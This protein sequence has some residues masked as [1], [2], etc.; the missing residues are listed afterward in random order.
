MKQKIHVLFFVF[1]NITSGS[2]FQKCQGQCISYDVH[3]CIDYMDDLHVQGNQMWWVNFGGSNPG[4]HSNCSGDVLSVNGNPWGLWS[5]PYTLAGVTNCMDMTSSVTLCSDICNLIQAPSAS[6]NWETIY[7]F[8]DSGPSGP[9]N[10]KIVF[11]YCPTTTIPSST[12]SVSATVCAGNNASF[13]YTGG[14]GSSAT[15]S[16]NFVDGSPLDTAKN[17]THTYANSGTYSV[18]LNVN[19]CNPSA[20]TIIPVTVSTTPTSACTTGTSICIGTN[21][22]ITYTGTGVAS[23]TYTWNF[24]GGNIVSGSG[25]GPYIVN[26]ATAGTQLVTLSVNENGCIS[27][28]ST[29]T[30]I[31][32]PAPVAN[33]KGNNVCFNNV[34][35]FTDLSVGNNTV[36]N[37]S[38]NF[39]DGNT[40]TLQSPTH[41]YSNPGSYSVT[42]TITNNF[43]CID[44]NSINV[45]V[46]PLPTV[47]FSSTTICLGNSTCFG[48][49]STITSGSIIGWGWNFG[50]PNSGNNNTST[51]QNPCHTYTNVGTFPVILTA[52]SDSGCQILKSLP[53]TINQLPVA[54]F[55]A[56][57]VC[58]NTSATFANGT[59][60]ASGD[61]IATWNWNFGNAPAGTSAAQNPAYSYGT[62]GT[63]SVTLIA[64]S[65]KGCIDTIIKS[66]T[67]YK[68]PVAAFSHP[69]SG[70]APLNNVGFVNASTSADGTITNWLWNFSGGNP[71]S[72]IQ[73][74]PS[75]ISFNNPGTYNVSLIVMTN[76]GCRD[77]LQS[78][79]YIKVFNL[80]QAGFCI[81]PISA[82]T[83]VNQPIFNFCN[84]WSAD[85]VQWTWNFGDGTPT[86]N[87]STNPIHS[88]STTAI[89]NS[90]YIYNVC[91][92]VLNQHGCR[93]SICK[94]V[95]LLPEFE[96]YAPNSFTP[97]G[98]GIN[99][100]FFGKGRG[101]TDYSIWI[102]DRWGNSVWD[103]HYSGKNIDWDNDNFNGHKQDG[104][105]SA[106]KWDGKAISGG[107]SMNGSSGNIS[108]EEVYVWK[109]EIIDIFDKH[110]TYTGNV[111][112][113]K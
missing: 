27:P 24:S 58:L 92:N 42:L 47:N 19:A 86:D 60:P 95:E 71:S 18:S 31:V 74:N 98:D 61:P 8:D 78:N 55:T 65:T 35:T 105:S 7:R 48:N 22:T 14:A 10:Y 88:Y 68:N 53:T 54:S 67:V 75:G 97:N 5:T 106:C 50:D 104:M 111:T 82:S 6:N 43:G 44:T 28:L 16:W 52:T 51:L 1:S 107:T 57:N 21:N 89:N 100:F 76:F 83:S 29:N 87:I 3:A 102:F 23:D 46:N 9:H 77:T 49:S 91:I 66:I 34:N 15:F 80:P 69:D 90:D 38:W 13:T 70:C 37:W 2:F 103:C 36:S 59:T 33:Q 99:D 84:Q 39:G 56:P 11:T 30:V 96:F 25:Q 72:S 93:D 94:K 108:Q 62:S 17:P 101:I 79:Q 73:Q 41:T 4:Q 64:I 85:V 81:D 113:V 63:Y 32:N 112:V 26:W 12:F 40:S 110:H 45:V 20:A 109:V